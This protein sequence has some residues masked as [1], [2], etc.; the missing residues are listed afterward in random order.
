MV[1]SKAIDCLAES[2]TKPCKFSAVFNKLG[3][4]SLYILAALSNTAGVAENSPQPLSQNG[5]IS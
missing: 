4:S 2:G 1:E 3:E 5:T